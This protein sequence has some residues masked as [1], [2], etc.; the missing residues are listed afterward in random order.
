DGTTD[1]FFAL[2]GNSLSAIRLTGRVRAALHHPISVRDLFEAPTVLALESRLTANAPALT[3]DEP[4][5]ATPPSPRST[6]T[7]TPIPLS[8]VQARLWTINYLGDGR[9]DYISALLFTFEGPLN[10]D[11]LQAALTDLTT[12]HEVLRTVF[13]YGETGPEQRI[14]PADTAPLDFRTTTLNTNTLNKEA[15][16]NAALGSDLAAPLDSDRAPAL[17][18][19]LT[20]ALNPNLTAAQDRDLTAALNPDLTAA[21]DANLTESLNP[22]LTATQ[23]PDLTAALNTAISTE[24]ATPFNLQ[25]HLPL[26][27]RLYLHDHDAKRHT[28]L[29]AIHHIA[30]DGHSAAP[31]HRDLATAYTA[32]AAGQ[33]PTWPAPAPQYA[34]YTL[35]RHHHTADEAHPDS[36]AARYWTQ[37]LTNLPTPLPLPRTHRP[38]HP[39]RTG[40]AATLPFTITPHLHTALE[41]AARQCSATT[42]MA[43]HAAFAAAL[44]AAGAG[45]DIPI[46]V[47]LSGRDT[48]DLDN[49]IGCLINTVVLRTRTTGTPT[50]RTLITQVRDRLLAAHEHQSLPFDHLVTLLNPPRSE[51]H[52]PLFQVAMTYLHHPPTTPTPHPPPPPPHHPPP[53]QPPHHPHRQHSKR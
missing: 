21:P 14:L 2:G 36:P 24:L 27:A 30:F 34:D 35:T 32:R 53:G 51:T 11:A 9:P 40:K 39:A 5:P 18:P 13:P 37:E 20:T 28:L 47:P 44:T 43:V 22:D 29:L 12:R 41:T 3:P 7:P 1:N 17:D 50:P 49:L 42:Y 46:G 4:L 6:P 26:R 38:S 19:Y 8:P 15:A 16:L 25:H 10:T 45:D 52:H 31:L 33:S 48:P 23:D